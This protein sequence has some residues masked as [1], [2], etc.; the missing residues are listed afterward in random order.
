MLGVSVLSPKGFGF[1]LGTRTERKEGDKKEEASLFCTTRQKQLLSPTAN[2]TL[3]KAGASWREEETATGIKHGESSLYY[4]FPRDITSP[5]SLFRPRVFSG[6]GA[7]FL[8]PARENADLVSTSESKGR[9]GGING[10]D[11]SRNPHS[12]P[13][14]PLL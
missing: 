5:L 3:K 4:C 11:P 9:E 8:R 12:H 1:E 6:S 7:L 2:A 14:T 10:R 13:I